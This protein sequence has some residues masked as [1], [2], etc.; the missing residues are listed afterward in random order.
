M[1]YLEEYYNKFMAII[2]IAFLTVLIADAKSVVP[3][4]VVKQGETRGFNLMISEEDS[5][6]EIRSDLNLEGKTIS[7][8]VPIEVLEIFIFYNRFII[9]W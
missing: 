6:Y 8:H 1:Y 2:L 7:F 5:I 4:S 3:K 9:Y